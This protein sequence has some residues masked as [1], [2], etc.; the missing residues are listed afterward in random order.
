MTVVVGADDAKAT[1]DVASTTI[2]GYEAA[3]YNFGDGKPTDE[4]DNKLPGEA[5]M[6]SVW[7]S[8]TKVSFGYFDKTVIVWYCSVKP[9]VGTPAKAKVNIGAACLVDTVNKCFNDAARLAHNKYRKMHA[10]DDLIYNAEIAKH[11]QTFMD[12]GT[13]AGA[14]VAPTAPLAA[15]CDTI[16]YSIYEESDAK[17]V[18]DLAKTDIVTDTW[19]KE[20]SKYDFST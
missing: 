19:Y 10:A 9:E 6:R 3:S 17:K 12:L 13:F 16:T 5:F 8:N 18:K 7:K 14:V 20:N 11:I 4:A 15:P 1:R 2:N